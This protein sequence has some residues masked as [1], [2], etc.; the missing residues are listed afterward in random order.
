MQVAKDIKDDV[1]AAQKLRLPGW[2]VVCLI[3]GALPLYWLFD[4]FGKLNIALPTLNCVA[5]ILLV[6]ALKWR[7]RQHAWFWITMSVVA[8]LHVPLILFVPWS[9]RWVPALAIAA[10]DSAD[11]IVMLAVLAF[12]GKLF[13]GPKTSER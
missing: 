6:V 12:I 9:T 10:V 2:G 1:G 5:T 3:G 8:A 13:D 4:H 11:L 7:L